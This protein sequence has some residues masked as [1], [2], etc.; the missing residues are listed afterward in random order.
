MRRKQP[1]FNFLKKFHITKKPNYWAKEDTSIAKLN[2]VLIP[3]MEGKQKE[4][5]LQSKHL[6][7]ICDVFKGEWTDVVKDVI[8]KC[9]GKMVRFCNNCT[10]HFQ[11]LDLTVNKRWCD[12]VTIKIPYGVDVLLHRPALHPIFSYWV[13]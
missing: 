3:Y 4:S 10:N 12:G 13:G 11:L 9:N 8:K 2:E 6:L 1:K 7:L 5:N